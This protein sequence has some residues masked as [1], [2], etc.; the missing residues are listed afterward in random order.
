[1]VDTMNAFV[2]NGG[3]IRPRFISNSER[4]SL[5]SLLISCDF[6]RS[7]R[8]LN[9]RSLTFCSSIRTGIGASRR[10]EG[11]LVAGATGG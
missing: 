11:A 9:N 5:I 10:K 1:V 2:A 3:W 4:V 6:V 8:S 7:R